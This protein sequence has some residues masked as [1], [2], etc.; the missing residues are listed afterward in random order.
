VW[1]LQQIGPSELT[2]SAVAASESGLV[3]CLARTNDRAEGDR[4]PA[5]GRRGA[6]YRGGAVT[7]PLAPDQRE[8]RRSRGAIKAAITRHGIVSPRRNT[9]SRGVASMT[10][11]NQRPWISQPSARTSTP[12]SSS[13][14]NC[15][16]SSGCTMPATAARCGRALASRRA[17]ISVSAGV[18]TLTTTAWAHAELDDHQAGAAG[19]DLP[20]DVGTT[21]TLQ[22]P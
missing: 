2:P 18:R 7:S 10:T 6:D 9:P 11:P 1:L 19:E 3:G 14:H 21:G 13:R 12:V 5:R 4:L 15:H 22:N 17:A 8:P 20:L 16:R